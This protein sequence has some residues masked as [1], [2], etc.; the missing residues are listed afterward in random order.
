M[1]AQLSFFQSPVSVPQDVQGAVLLPPGVAVSV[2]GPVE[3]AAQLP[4]DVLVAL[5]AEILPLPS[6]SILVMMRA[7]LEVVHVTP[8]MQRRW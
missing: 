2:P 6:T 3:R 5:H 1:A 7:S 8:T 4:G